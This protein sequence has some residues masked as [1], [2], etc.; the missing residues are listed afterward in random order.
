MLCHKAGEYA[1][2]H[3]EGLSGFLST[4][5]QGGDTSSPTV[6]NPWED[7]VRIMT[8][9]K[10]KGLEFP[11][12]YLLGLEDPIVKRTLTK[13]ISMHPQLGLGLMYMNKGARTKRATLLQNVI[14][15]R[16]KAEARAEKA[17]VL[18]VAM[19]RP[20]NRLVMVACSDQTMQNAEQLVKVR[21]MGGQLSL[22]RSAKTLS[23]W[24]L[25]SVNEEELQVEDHRT[26]EPYIKEETHSEGTE[27]RPETGISTA[28]EASKEK[29][30]EQM[31]FDMFSTIGMWETQGNSLSS[32]VPTCFPQKSGVW[33]VVFH[34]D[35]EESIDSQRQ[36]NVNADS[37]VNMTSFEQILPTVSNVADPLTPIRPQQPV[38]LKVGV[39][40]LCRAMAEASPIEAEEDT[41][42]RK[43]YPLLTRQPK[44]LSSLRSKPE[45]LLP[46]QEDAALQRGV[47]TH[48]LLSTISIDAARASLT[49]GNVIDFLEAHRE[50]LRLSGRFSIQEASVADVKMAARFLM[51]E[52]GRN[53]LRSKEIR[54]E[55][56]FNLRIHQPIETMVQGVIDL[57]YLEED[58]WVLIDFKTDYVTSKEELWQK[59]SMQLSFYRQAL[60]KA[61]GRKVRRCG[62]YSLRLG[63]LITGQIE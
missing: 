13:N 1:E 29:Q 37:D 44:L 40:A 53:M 22:V 36:E 32:T 33:R 27:N 56:P 52:E 18:Y 20:K 3:T 48:L 17:R 55:W 47:C 23:D 21:E 54:R 14:D 10:S 15:M 19:T 38:P 24:V 41:P 46:R 25:Q 61:T 45:F 31:T 42:E 34:R 12:V 5:H 50:N 39:T 26:C 57:C 59:Y 11:T 62:L 49:E 8:I 58:E 7:V 35:T 63:Q 51:S 60:E 30:Q 28:L 43:R 4:L 9:H 6:V 2:S 16:A